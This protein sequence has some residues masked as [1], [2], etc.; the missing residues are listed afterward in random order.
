L[1]LNDPGYESRLDLLPEL[2]RLRLKFGIWDA[3]EGQVFTE[4]SQRVHSCEDFDVSPDWERI[5]VL[6]WGF[7]KPFCVYWGAVDYD[8]VI[9]I[10]RE[11]YGCKREALND[12]EGV[13]MGLKLQ[14]WEVAKGILER[15]KGEKIRIRVAD[16]SIYHPLADSRK[17]EARGPSVQ[18]DMAAQGVYFLKA[19]NDRLQG[20]LQ[21]HKRLKLETDIDPETGEIKDERAMLK[22]ANS[23]K[24]FWRTL[25][26]LREDPKNPE[27]VDTDQEDHCYDAVRYLCMA[28]PIRPKKVSVIAQGSFQ[29]ER[30]KLIRAKKYAR[31]HGVSVNAAYSRIR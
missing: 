24:G 25:P 3:F 7:A 8:G 5:C 14:A 9:W 19:D 6:D 11:W 2:E 28:R 1:E 26:L 10:Y 20:K 12:P 29:H 16:P 4:L 27:D 13:D 15:E 18:E 17:K 22:V 31:T 23:C 30:M 21:F